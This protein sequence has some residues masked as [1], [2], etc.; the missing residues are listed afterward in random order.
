[1][2]L[3][4]TALEQ[5]MQQDPW[6]LL[7]E[8]LQH[9][10]LPKSRSESLATLF[11]PKRKDSHKAA[12]TFKATASEGLSLFPIFTFFLLHIVQPMAILQ[13]E[14]QAYVELANILEMLQSTALEVIAAAQLKEHIEK[15]LQKC[16]ACN[17][18][19]HFHP[20]FHWMLHLPLHLQRWG[21]LPACF[22]H[23]RKHRVPKKYGGHITNTRQYER[24]LLIEILGH[25]IAELKENDFFCQK[26]MLQ[27]KGKASKR[28]VAFLEEY[29][30]Q[31]A[32]TAF[33][34]AAACLDPAGHCHR[35]DVV[36]LKG[37]S[38][39]AEVW[40]HAEFNGLTASLLCMYDQAAYD[41]GQGT[42]ICSK[43]QCPMMVPTEDILCAL[44]HTW[45]DEQHCRILI[46]LPHRR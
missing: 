16:L 44:C 26:A 10:K 31:Q 22:V 35:G 12:K 7:A 23:E 20:K 30:E 32:E 41:A 40:F 34:C 28:M 25:D 5:Q 21:F 29:F 2:F 15:F 45:L 39:V 19:N 33:T 8:Y 17:W 24:S 9:W 38:Q 37:S 14:I 6:S 18:E 43:Q 36:L 1:M 4:M 42:A 3:V 13:K 11:S 46:P 27:K